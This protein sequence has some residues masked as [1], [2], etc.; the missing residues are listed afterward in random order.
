M[1][2]PNGC[3]DV[4]VEFQPAISGELVDGGLRQPVVGME[5]D[6]LAWVVTG[7]NVVSRTGDMDPRNQLLC[8]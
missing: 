4:T 1:R 7:I 3:L 6:E 8:Q 5:G 2:P